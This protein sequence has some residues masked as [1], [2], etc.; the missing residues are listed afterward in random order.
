MGLPVA[1]SAVDEVVDCPGPPSRR[2]WAGAAM[3]VVLIAGIALLGVLGLFVGSHSLP[4]E[5]VLAAL[6]G[7]SLD[8]TSRVIVVRLRLPRFAVALVAGSALG[9]ATAI[10]QSMTRNPLAEP[11][12]LG[13]NS[14][15]SLAVIIG[16][17]QFGLDS[18][19]AT[20]GLAMFGA[21]AAGALVLLLGGAFA[22]VVAPIRL[23][24]AGAA[25]SAVFGSLASLL[26]LS[27][28]SAFE[29]F[30]HW[31]AGGVTARPW[32]LVTVGAVV[33]GIGLLLG[34]F[35]APGL[36]SLALGGELGR[37][38]GA[39]AGRTWLCASLAVVV[40]CGAATALVGPIGFLG[41]L[42]TVAARRLARGGLAVTMPLAALLATNVLLVAD[43]IGRVVAAPAEMQA[44][45][46]CALFGAPAFVMLAS[47]SR[48]VTA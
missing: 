40:L 33:S 19:L 20:M 34:L 25:I 26:I 29:S 2:R 28:P 10:I 44:G 42:A 32:A 39:S 36:D 31:D 16:I 46:V 38:L 27:Y 35:V 48:V 45:I 18:H 5:R 11:G 43:L 22:G 24:L 15:A 30:R 4:P 6:T 8:E 41:L 9:A 12:L 7:D 13:I 3:P 17:V 21:C 14:G 23:V 37:A 47:R 1:A